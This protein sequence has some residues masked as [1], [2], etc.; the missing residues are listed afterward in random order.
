VKANDRLSF[1]DLRLSLWFVPSVAA[2]V[3]LAVA[4]GLA[5]VTPSQD[6]PLGRLPWP[7]DVQAAS[8]VLQVIA[9]ATITVTS[10]TF[11]LVVVA[12]QLASQQFSPR[13]LREFA[14]DWVIQAVLAVLVST[15]VFSLTILM[16]LDSSE[17]AP[18][19]ATV[20][21][22]LLGL[23]SVA[24]LLTFLGHI[25]R[26]LRIDTMMVAV[27][28]ETVDT[29]EQSYPSV[30]E[31]EP[32][33]PHD[34]VDTGGGTLLP[35]R[36]SGFVK[37][38]QPA[39]LVRA[40]AEADAVLWMMIRPGDHL[41]E[42]TPV[43]IAYRR[44]G[45]QVSPAQAERLTEA[46]LQA[47]ELGYER[48]AEQDTALGLRQLVDIAVKALSPGINDP[49][50]AAHAVGYLSDLLVRLQSRRLGP[51]VHSDD[52]DTQRL[53]LPDRDARYYLDLACGQIRRYGRREPTV[54]V[55]LLRM[56]RDVAVAAPDDQHRDEI[57]RQSALIVAEMSEDLHPEDV[58]SVH[59]L[60]TRVE[61]ALGGRVE[62]AFG[63]RAGET[64]SI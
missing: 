7:A 30:H 26:A 42:G 47:V 51:Q 28:G 60:A 45:T 33:R 18:K 21:A 39:R 52:D 59:D 4:L 57:R 64:R 55:A 34:V 53:V 14:R 37:V 22:F 43:G 25:V 58:A 1:E 3:A 23:L 35:A 27:H 5:Q 8:T 10:L 54:L 61:Q 12:L 48:T 11:S 50:T 6:E 24:A 2:V 13:L 19:V 63:D 49:V 17:P 40:A 29:M 9:T 62:Q 20:V 44:D 46:I 31:P 15:F 41:V 38:I 56:L 32:R 16:A 36:R